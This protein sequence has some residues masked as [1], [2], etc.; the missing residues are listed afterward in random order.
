MKCPH[1]IFHPDYL[2]MERT[3]KTG[4]LLFAI[5]VEIAAVRA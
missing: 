4:E 3:G 1:R 5:V 2:V